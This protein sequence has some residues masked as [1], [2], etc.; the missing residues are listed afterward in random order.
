M[1]AFKT[2]GLRDVEKHPPYMHDGSLAT[3]KDVVEFYNRGGHPEV[4]N[5]R[6]APLGL[7]QA[8]VDAVVAFL[9]ALNGEG[10]QD[11]APRLFA[12]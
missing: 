9:K 7:S 3:L 2:P 11:R 4:R 6:I 1:G 5:G 12:Q 8:D 10:Y